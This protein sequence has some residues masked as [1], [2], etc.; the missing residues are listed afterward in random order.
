MLDRSLPTTPVAAHVYVDGRPYRSVLAN[1]RRADVARAHPGIGEL[2][3][4]DA[5]LTLTPGA[6]S[7]CVFAINVGVVGS[8]R[9]VRCASVTA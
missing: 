1:G 4:L 6:H 2:H 9:L 5:T 7:V 3:G 8:N